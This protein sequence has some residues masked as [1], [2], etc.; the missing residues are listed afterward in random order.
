MSQRDELSPR[1]DHGG[2]RSGARWRAVFTLPDAMGWRDQVIGALVAAVYVGWLLATARSLGFPRDEG[3]YFHAATDY[4]RWFEMLLTHPAAALKRGAI[5]GAWANNHEHPALMKSLFALSWMLFHERIKLFS[6]AST[7][8][9]LPGM[10]MGGLSLWVTYLFGARVFSRREGAMGAVLL[11]LM[12]TIFF[13]AHLAC[14]DVPIMT[15]W[16]VSVYVYWRATQE[17][18]VG[19]VLFA[20][21][22]YGLALETKHNAWILPAVFVAHTLLLERRSLMRF[23]RAGH[24]HIPATL[25]SIAIVGPLVF[26]GLWPWL[27]ND[28]AARLR[29]YVNFHLHHEYYNIE[30]LGKNYFGPPSPPSYVLVLIVATVPTITLVLFAL[31]ALDRARAM[32]GRVLRAVQGE[33]VM[34]R[35]RDR[36]ETDVLLLLSLAAP[37]AVFL[38]PATPIF[39]GTKHWLP[40]YPFLA[41]FAGHGFD[42][43][44]RSMAS[45]AAALGTYGS[46]FAP[47]GLAAVVIAAPLAETVHSHPFG[48][49]AYTPIVGGT[50]GGADLGL[51]RQFWGFTTESV[52]P[53][54]ATLPRG[55]SVFIHDTAWD[56]WSRMLDEGRV[57]SDLRGAGSPSDATVAL[58]HHELHMQEVDF[59]IW[60]AYGTLAPAYVLTHDGVP[61]VSVYRRQ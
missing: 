27:W 39:G 35:A 6:D 48:L 61:I 23:V 20:G 52:A 16:L 34:E 25:L 54:L 3:F 30:Y 47:S 22:A 43:A 56:S 2:A 46:R 24:V 45:A 58:V 5:D 11:G 49:S 17:R 37:L 33:P 44:A 28:T 50:A 8:F 42:L 59:G 32:S 57:R 10:L 41:L 14:F 13:H 12:P 53:F 55:A 19:W 9:R 15:M 60:M 1:D 26:V 51:N 7:A 18:S 4:A 31:G 21:V 29:E 40:A 38:L 36:A